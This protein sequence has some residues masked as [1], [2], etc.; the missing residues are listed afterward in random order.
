[1]L[2]GGVGSLFLSYFEFHHPDCALREEDGATSGG[3]NSLMH[4][5]GLS[6]SPTTIKRA[7]QDH[8]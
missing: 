5:E 6:I 1:M 7:E 8:R 3:K 4:I 2:R